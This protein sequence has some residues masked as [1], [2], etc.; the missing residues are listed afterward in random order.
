MTQQR[1]PQTPEAADGYTERFQKA[2]RL[3]RRGDF[4]KLSRAGRRI[5]SPCFIAVVLPRASGRS[6]LGITVTR[7][8]ANAA[9]RNRIKRICREVFRRRRHLLH[10]AWDLNLIARR[11][12]VGADTSEL[13]RSLESIFQRINRNEG[14]D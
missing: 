7:K 14:Q 10:R 2:D 1:D 8:V 12:A 5:H 4:L 3:L 6:R 9:K 13:S 11:Q